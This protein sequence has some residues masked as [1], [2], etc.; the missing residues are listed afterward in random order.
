MTIRGVDVSSHQQASAINWQALAETHQFL[1]ARGTYG[2]RP[3]SQCA[4]HV[5]CA[6]AAGLVTGLYHFFRPGQPVADQLTAFTAVA[7]TLSVDSS[8]IVPALDLEANERYDGPF[9]A[10]R[11]SEPCWT[12]AEFLQQR[13]GGCLIYINPSDWRTLGRPGWVLSHHVWL[14]QWGVRET[15]PDLPWAIWQHSVAALPG[16]YASPIDQ[17]VARAPLPL[18]TTP[19]VVPDEDWEVDTQVTRAALTASAQQLRDAMAEVRELELP[20]DRAAEM[21]DRDKDV[22][23][24]DDD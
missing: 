11:Y 6:R 7:D 23:E 18:V 17:N 3:D 5:E 4:A 15:T 2:T 14:A 8:W 20:R 16:V 21:T 1:I 24:R 9:S 12:I 19:E 13:Y 10:E 22:R